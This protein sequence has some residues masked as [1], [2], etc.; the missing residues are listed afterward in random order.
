MGGVVSPMHPNGN[1]PQRSNI[2]EPAQH[3]HARNA[4]GIHRTSH[5][6]IVPSPQLHLHLNLGRRPKINTQIKINGNQK[7]EFFLFF[8]TRIIRAWRPHNTNKKEP[9][10]NKKNPS[11]TPKRGRKGKIDP[12]PPRWKKRIEEGKERLIE[13]IWLQRISYTNGI[14]TAP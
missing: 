11:P 4:W 10:Q 7:K 1:I 9:P 3:S 5:F 14:Q 13:T 2:F 6:R 8:P 12:N